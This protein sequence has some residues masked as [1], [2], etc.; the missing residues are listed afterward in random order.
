LTGVGAQRA[1]T[2]AS[3]FSGNSGDETSSESGSRVKSV[4]I[5]FCLIKGGV[6][7]ESTL[8]GDYLNSFS[9]FELSS[10]NLNFL[11]SA[12][13]IFFDIFEGLISGLGLISVEGFFVSTTICLST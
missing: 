9:C 11:D 12:N 8:V 2:F 3:C 13:P 6:S 4:L 1:C 7:L 5:Y 10:A